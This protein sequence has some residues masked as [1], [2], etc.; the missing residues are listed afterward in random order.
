MTKII[1]QIFEKFIEGNENPFQTKKEVCVGTT[2]VLKE[3]GSFE[4]PGTEILEKTLKS[5]RK[6][7]GDGIF[8]ILQINRRG[9][10]EMAIIFTT[11]GEL[12]VPLRFLRPV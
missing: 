10:T 7:L 11:K 12:E 9:A 5:Y 8:K 1:R 4:K 6:V 3:T 2:V